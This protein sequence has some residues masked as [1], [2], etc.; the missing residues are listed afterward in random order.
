MALP[1][2]FCLRAVARSHG[3]YEIPPFSWDDEARTL[4]LAIQGPRGSVRRLEMRQGSGRQGSSSRLSLAWISR[5]QPPGEASARRAREE[6]GRALARRVLNL[7]WALG[8]FFELCVRTPPLAWVPGAGAGWILRGPGLFSDLVSSICGTNIAWKQAVRMVHRLC[9]IAPKDP[10]GALPRY[11]T[12]AELLGAGSEHLRGHARLGYR[13]DSVLRLC[14]MVMEGRL[15]LGPAERGELDGPALRGFFQSVPGIGP[16]TAR[17]LGALYGRFDALAVDSLVLTFLADTRF[18]GRKPS[19]AEVQA[20]FE[21]FGDLRALAYWF[22]FL[23]AV[24]PVT[25]RGW[26]SEEKVEKARR[27]G[28]AVRL[29]RNGQAS[30]QA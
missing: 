28:R 5:G 7:D 3:W 25:W 15:D 30:E 24:D 20:L 27:V 6:E 17:Y 10:L 4:A 16:V 14:E 21:P 8:P 18:G 13:A 22:E 12:P 29:E 2:R 26:E 1:P 11:P 19:E 23:G 9:D